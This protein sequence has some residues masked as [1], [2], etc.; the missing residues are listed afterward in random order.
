MVR[1]PEQV[2]SAV[3]TLQEYFDQLPAHL[4]PLAAPFQ[5]SSHARPFVQ[6]P[7]VPKLAD[8]RGKR[9]EEEEFIS[10]HLIRSGNRRWDERHGSER[11]YLRRKGI[12]RGEI[13]NMEK[14]DS[15]KKKGNK[16]RTFLARKRRW[17]GRAGRHLV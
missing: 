6:I 4:M 8:L 7:I 5:V 3:E 1:S 9:K 13:G 15:S 12:F 11:L 14:V 17:Q 2:P 10:K 16:L